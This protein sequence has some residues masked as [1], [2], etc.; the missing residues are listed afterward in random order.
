MKWKHLWRNFGGNIF[1]PGRNS[2]KGKRRTFPSSSFRHC[3]LEKTSQRQEARKATCIRGRIE[4]N[5]NKT[6]GILMPLSCSEEIWGNWLLLLL[7]NAKCPVWAT[8]VHGLLYFVL[9]ETIIFCA[10]TMC[11]SKEFLY[12]WYLTMKFVHC[13]YFPIFWLWIIPWCHTFVMWCVCVW[14]SYHFPPT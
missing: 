7:I 6:P 13:A 4:N 5:N 11:L 3:D 1:L 10:R 9:A 12:L 14:P 8:I 2:Q